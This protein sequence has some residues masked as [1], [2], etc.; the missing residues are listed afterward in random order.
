MGAYTGLNTFFKGKL[1]DY[2]A[3]YKYDESNILILKNDVNDLKNR[4]PQIYSNI[5]SCQHHSDRRTP[6]QYAQDL[7]ASWIFEDYFL[8]EMKSS[9][10]DIS[11][12]GSDRSRLILQNTKTTTNSDYVITSKSG[13]KISIELVNDYTVFWARTHKLHLR[14]NKYNQLKRNKCLLLAVSLSDQM[15]KYALFDFRKDI[16]ATYIAKHRPYGYKPAYEINI[17]SSMMGNFSISEVQKT[18]MNVI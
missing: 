2:A 12:S 17:P 13:N 1:C 18:I 8:H 7:V 11:L 9:N 3:A 16:P 15:Q 6:I 5:L 4:Y 14:D 10:F